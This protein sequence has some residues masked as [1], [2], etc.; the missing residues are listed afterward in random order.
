MRFA[1]GFLLLLISDANAFTQ[2]SVSRSL[3]RQAT[4]PSTSAAGPSPRS[5]KTSLYMST[6]TGRDFYQILGVT[7][8]A[9]TSEI[10]SAYRKL[11]KQYHPGTLEHQTFELGA[12]KP[13]ISV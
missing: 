12:K 4:L 2:P 10:K 11:A 1:A 3:G 6:R 7:R 9:D 5:S 13:R 8:S